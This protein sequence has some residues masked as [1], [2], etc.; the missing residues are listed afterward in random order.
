[1]ADGFKLVGTTGDQTIDVKPGTT[2]V[3]GR[4]VNSD[5]PI[6]DPTISRQHAQLTV[7]NGGVQVKDLGS[8]NGTFINGARITEGNLAPND[9][10]T[11]GKVVFQLK[12]IEA[13]PHRSMPTGPG[14]QAPGATI[15]RQVAPGT[16]FGSRTATEPP[17]HKKPIQPVSCGALYTHTKR[18]LAYTRG[19][20]ALGAVVVEDSQWSHG[21]APA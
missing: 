18:V 12:S 7:Q 15:V 5:V 10:V 21:L 20:S 14:I 3:V 6:Y 4:A 8:S 9:S 13:T 17:S 16:G 1:M 19:G 11:F 2:M